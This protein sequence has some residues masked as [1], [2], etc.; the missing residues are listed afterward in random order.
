MQVT[1]L[2]PEDRPEWEALYRGYA[3]FYKVALTTEGM[4]ALWSWIFDDKEPVYAIVARNAQGKA[5]GLMHYREM[6]SPL[7]GT[8]AG[9][10]DD[11]FVQP[12]CRGGGAVDALFARL[13]EEAKSRG[14]PFVRWLTGDDNFRA[15]AVY[16]GLA[17][18]TMW[19]TY[20][21]NVAPAR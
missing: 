17:T 7:R 8:K 11:L 20:Q 15:R 1:L 18:R 19:I 16:D 3:A 2:R 12:D 9:F 10:L 13:T 5:I 14:W 6:H 4:N 21:M